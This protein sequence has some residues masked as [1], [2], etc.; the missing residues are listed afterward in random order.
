MP[1]PRLLQPDSG[2]RRL[3]RIEFEMLSDQLLFGHHLMFLL[4]VLLV[5]AVA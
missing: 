4:R 5:V 1:K 2:Q 3:V